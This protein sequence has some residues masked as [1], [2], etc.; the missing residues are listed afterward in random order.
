MPIKHR[1]HQDGDDVVGDRKRAQ[2]HAHPAGNLVAQK[3]QDAKRERNVGS[4]GHAPAKSGFGVSRIEGQVD[5]DGREHAA[6]RS[7]D[8]ED[9]LADVG[10]LA[11]R[12]L[13]FDLQSHQ[14]EKQSHEQ[15][16]HHMMERHTRLLA[17]KEEPHLHLEDLFK[18]VVR[19]I[20]RHD[21]RRH[22]RQ[23]HDEC[24]TRGGMGEVDE[25]TIAFLVPLNFIDEDVVG[26]VPPNFE[27]LP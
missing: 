8:G 9:G 4:S 3:R 14:Q 20:V 7:H 10:K 1:D 12:H 2:E 19:G 25:L 11:H 16:V 23:Q 15:V 6:Q 27:G 26:H 5:A 17:A 22:C 13:I 21:E 18:R 24:R